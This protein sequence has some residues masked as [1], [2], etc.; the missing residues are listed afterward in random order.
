MRETHPA[1]IARPKFFTPIGG[2]VAIRFPEINDKQRLNPISKTF[3]SDVTNVN[4]KVVVVI[5][6]LHVR[7]L[8]ALPTVVGRDC[9]RARRQRKCEIKT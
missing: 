7:E 5:V 9:C 6:C 4:N 2:A 3:N 1:T 8:L